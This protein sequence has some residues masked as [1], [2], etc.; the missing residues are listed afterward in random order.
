M[1]ITSREREILTNI[2]GWS[3]PNFARVRSLFTS[4]MR[5]RNNDRI[6]IRDHRSKHEIDLEML[7]KRIGGV[8]FVT[9]QAK[10]R[11]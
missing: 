3:L 7:S 5:S 11:N 6:D 10:A 9:F 4:G 8:R 2:D 1:P